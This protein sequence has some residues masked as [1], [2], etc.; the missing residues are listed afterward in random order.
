LETIGQAWPWVA[1]TTALIA[2]TA[3]ILW[4]RRAAGL[5]GAWVLL[6][7]SPTLIVPIITEA[8]AERR[9]Y[10]PLAGIALLAV[11]GSFSLAER[12]PSGQKEKQRSA[13][14]RRGLSVIVAV[15][16]I[17]L[18]VIYSFVDVN[19]LAAF[20][21][22]ILL[23]QDTIRRGTADS[24]A[25]NNLGFELLNAN[26]QKEAVEP[27]QKALALNQND[28]KIYTNL[29]VVLDGL[30]RPEEAIE[31]FQAALKLDPNY[32]VAKR[33]L[34]LSLGK[35]GRSGEAIAELDSVVK[36]HPN[37]AAAHYDLGIALGEA[38]RLQEAV[39]EFERAIAIRPRY[40]AAYNN[41]GVALVKLNQM[42]RAADALEAALVLDPNSAETHKNL[43]I[44]LL[45]A[46]KPQQ[47]VDHLKK[48]AAAARSQENMA[49]AEAIENQLKSL[50]AQQNGGK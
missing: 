28:P 22:P 21:S 45:N 32:A 19:R 40:E 3:Y 6:I 5:A 48:A 17:A 24:F 13:N 38:R 23:W 12:L 39:E 42:D 20:E 34:A 25:Y 1:A 30:G 50:S 26:R 9:M 10:L 27:L 4:R 2:G 18:A 41:L 43:G 49:L 46:G 7:L 8:A 36:A 31:Q 47:A 33:D 37:S 29:G 44:V 15:A 35:V 14:K 16:G 11:A